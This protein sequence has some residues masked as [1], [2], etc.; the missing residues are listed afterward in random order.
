M[1]L[2]ARSVALAV[3]ARGDEVDL[4]ARA[5][6]EAGKPNETAALEALQKL[7]GSALEQR[8]GS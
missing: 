7:R 3:G 8:R 5:I 4:V 1:A 2:H 6:S